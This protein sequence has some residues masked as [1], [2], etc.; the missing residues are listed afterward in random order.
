MT[1]ARQWRL[2]VRAGWLQH[3]NGQA[4]RQLCRFGE[5]P[6]KERTSIISHSLF[7]TWSSTHACS[8]R[9]LARERRVSLKSRSGERVLG[10]ERF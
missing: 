5:D 1:A 7:A 6:T 8:A 10:D 4:R 3:K 2:V 9:T